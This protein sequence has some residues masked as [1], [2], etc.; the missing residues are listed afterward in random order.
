M[1]GYY[2]VI[3]IAGPSASPLILALN[4]KTKKSRNQN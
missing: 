4:L 3:L 1:L 2:A